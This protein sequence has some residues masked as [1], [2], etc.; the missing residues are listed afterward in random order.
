MKNTLVLFLTIFLYSGIYAGDKNTEKE[1]EAIKK[2]IIEATNAYRAKDYNRMA[3]TFVKNEST[4][5]IGSAKGG[6]FVRTGWEE[7]A[8]NYKQNF[9]NN[10]NPITREL[11]K[12]NFKIKVYKESAW[13]IHNEVQTLENGKV[14]KQIITH[15]L[16]KNDGKWEVV[17]MSQI[18]E[19]SYDVTN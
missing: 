2:V 12:I 15:F 14:A 10:P 13:S 18:F 16:E 9:E 8:A 6:F 7:I 4:I 5:K 17:F 3:A 1:T 19:S 11:N